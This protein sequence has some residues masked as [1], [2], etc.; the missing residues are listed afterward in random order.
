MLVK[1]SQSLRLEEIIKRAYGTH[2]LRIVCYHSIAT[3]HPFLPA[4]LCVSPSN[5]IEQ[6]RCLNKH[7]NII[8]FDDLD[9]VENRKVVRPLIVTF[10]DGLRDNFDV[11]FPILKEMGIKATFYLNTLPL[12]EDRIL[13]THHLYILARSVG[14][15]RLAGE[16]LREKDR[17]IS[18]MGSLPSVF[19]YVGDNYSYEEVFELYERFGVKPQAQ[20]M[21]IRENEIEELL[22]HGM[23][24]GCHGH[25]HFNLMKI[26]NAEDE[27]RLSKDC[28]ES[29]CRE[30]IGTFAYPFGDPDS[31]DETLN[32]RLGNL[33][34][35]LCTTLPRINRQPA[36]G[37]YHRVC[38]YEMPAE[39]LLLKLLIGI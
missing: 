39:K 5:F 26:E 32:N 38:S 13:W 22:A 15:E 1:I 23:G 19:R 29:L 33:F 30:K 7:F 18:G 10:D 35:S 6:L 4:H 20:G 37:L 27:V 17:G 31:F 16:I 25:T 2:S 21:Y 24:I 28:L 11:A 3:N 12:V 8:S 9:L 36:N 14:V 34:E